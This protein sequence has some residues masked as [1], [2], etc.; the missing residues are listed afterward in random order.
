[1]LLKKKPK[2]NAAKGAVRFSK[3]IRK[4]NF[5]A[6]VYFGPNDNVA[7]YIRRE[8][9]GLNS[10]VLIVTPDTYDIYRELFYGD[11]GKELRVEIKQF[12][13]EAKENGIA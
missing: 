7:I 12:L 9:K 6:D 2:N 5:R 10:F 8:D 3:T 11:T 1:M 4:G 13:K